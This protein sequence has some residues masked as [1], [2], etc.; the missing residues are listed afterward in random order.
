MSSGPAAGWI[1]GA[2]K[3][4]TEWGLGRPGDIGETK[5]IS[6]PSGCLR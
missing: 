4:K 3:S 2:L 1:M 6:V 5:D